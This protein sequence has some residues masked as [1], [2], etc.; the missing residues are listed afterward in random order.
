MK[1]RNIVL[2]IVFSIIT[3]GIYAIYW[4]VK[5]T[6]DTNKLDP[7]HATMGGVAAFFVSLVTFGIYGIYWY[8]KLG[9]KAGNIRNENSMGI[10]YLI[11]GLFGFGV[12][13]YCLAQSAINSHLSA[14]QT[15]AA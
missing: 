14:T 4:F 2:A 9:V 15:A 6:N 1:K 5:L 10:V 11:L 12:I 3:L 7:D 8:Y 13:D